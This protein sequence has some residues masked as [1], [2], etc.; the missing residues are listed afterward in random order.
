M[1]KKLF[2]SC[3]L[4]VGW[5]IGMLAANPQQAM[6]QANELYRQDNFAEAAQAYTDLWEQGFRSKALAYNLGN[7]YF[8][9]DSLGKAVLFYER[10]L[11][12]SPN[13]RAVKENLELLRSRIAEEEDELPVIGLI[14]VW[15]ALQNGISANAWTWLGLILVW[16]GITGFVFWQ[17]GTLRKVRKRGF[18][19]G[20]GLLILSVLPFS[21][22][23]SRNYDETQKITVVVMA[24]EVPLRTAASEGS[25]SIIDLYLGTKATVTDSI[26]NWREILLSNG[27]QGWIPSDQIDEI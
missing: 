8:R 11:R 25:E 9:L 4:M 18:L 17:I 22:A 24:N 13:D 12:I 26:G 6:Q 3:L 15:R 20:L 21:L 5:S 2:L 1:G 19:I 14:R 23:W 16:G 7:T 10:A 27:Y